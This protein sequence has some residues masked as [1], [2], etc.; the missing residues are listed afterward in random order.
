MTAKVLLALLKSTFLLIFQGIFRDK[1][2]KSLI[3]R[4]KSMIYIDKSL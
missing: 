4:D 3:Y 1:P 2:L